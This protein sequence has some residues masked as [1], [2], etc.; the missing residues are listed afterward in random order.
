MNE[1]VL[2]Q[3]GKNKLNYLDK[4]TLYRGYYVLLAIPTSS[5]TIPEVEARY[6]L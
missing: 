2:I 4:D 3:N 1:L 6:D 5:Q